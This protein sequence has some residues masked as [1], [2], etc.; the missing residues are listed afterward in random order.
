MLGLAFLLSV[1]SVAF[2]YGAAQ[3]IEPKRIGWF[4]N[5]EKHAK[6]FRIVSLFLLVISTILFSKTL[7]AMKGVVYSLIVW[8]STACITLL[9]VPLINSWK[10]KTK[11]KVQKSKLGKNASQ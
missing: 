1:L 3:K 11:T 9:F 6:P 4:T 7:G 10:T 2:L 8:I 5:L